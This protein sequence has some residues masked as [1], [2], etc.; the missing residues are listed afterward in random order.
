ME[1]FEN[2]WAPFPEDNILAEDFDACLQELEKLGSYQEVKKLRSDSFKM[3]EEA[4]CD[5]VDPIHAVVRSIGNP[6][7]LN[8]YSGK[9]RSKATGRAAAGFFVTAD[10]DCELDNLHI[11]FATFIATTDALVI[12][13]AD[14]VSKA[15]QIFLRLP[16]SAGEEQKMSLFGGTQF[17]N[18]CPGGI[19]EPGQLNTI[20][21]MLT[22][23][24]K[25]VADLGKK[26]SL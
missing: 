8:V 24:A 10:V 4:V 12:S 9:D 26:R 14:V 5:Y 6:V 13:F 22:V 17:V 16:I 23:S 7:E 2:K 3:R 1:N 25:A 15:P 19:L 21:K 11:S 18:V 20:E